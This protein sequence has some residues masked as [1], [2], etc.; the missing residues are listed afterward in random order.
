MTTDTLTRMNRVAVN[1]QMGRASLLTESTFRRAFRSV[2]FKKCSRKDRHD[3]KDRS[4]RAEKLTEK[5]LLCTHSDQDQHQ[6]DNSNLIRSIWKFS[7]CQHGK[8]IPRTHSLKGC[9]PSGQ[10]GKQKKCQKHIFHLLK[11][12]DC[13]FRIT[14]SSLFMKYFLSPSEPNAHAYPQKCLPNKIVTRRSNPVTSR[15]EFQAICWCAAIA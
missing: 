10:N 14:M 13:F 15:N 5:S 7:C 9:I 1:V 3:C 6:Q 11:N 4:H 2:S 8:Y 12:S